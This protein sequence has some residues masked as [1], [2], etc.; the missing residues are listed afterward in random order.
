MTNSSGV[1]EPRMTGGGG[2]GTPPLT[3]SFGSVLGL[4]KKRDIEGHSGW[5]RAPYSAA[6]RT[7]K[8]PF[9]DLRKATKLVTLILHNPSHRQPSPRAVSVG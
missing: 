9:L 4:L 1:R 2:A 7:P 3:R 8:S 6:Q 5:R